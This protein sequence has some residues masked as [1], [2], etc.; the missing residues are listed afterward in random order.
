MTGWIIANLHEL[1]GCA[2][3]SVD[4]GRRGERSHGAFRGRF[5]RIHVGPIQ[6]EIA[7]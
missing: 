5:A 7:V 3:F 4:D 2:Y 1:G 6:V